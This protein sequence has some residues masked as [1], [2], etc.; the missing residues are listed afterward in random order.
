MR[1]RDLPYYLQ[2]NQ[3]FVGLDDYEMI[4]A[5]N[6][7]KVMFWVS[8]AISGIFLPFDYRG[9]LFMLGLMGFIYIAFRFGY[10]EQI[11]AKDVRAR[12][13]LLT[14]SSS[15]EVS[16]QAKARISGQEKLRHFTDPDHEPRWQAW[17]DESGRYFVAPAARQLVLFSNKETLNVS[18]TV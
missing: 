14:G 15:V 18:P 9:A 3:V 6:Y 13:A 11:D 4:T 17:E 8:A 16:K 1:N 5:R 7:H 2:E 10:D 12:E